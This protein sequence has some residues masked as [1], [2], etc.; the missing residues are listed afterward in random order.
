MKINCKTLCLGL[1][2]A[3]V[4]LTQSARAE[5]SKDMIDAAVIADIKAFALTEIVQ[6]SVSN[7]NQ[8]YSHLSQAEI[9]QL[10]QKWRAETKQE[11]QPLISATLSSPLSS[12]FT[13][14]QAASHGLY[15]EMFAMD[16]KGLNVGQS[17]ISSDYWQGDEA[18][19]Q[20]T[21][22][23]GAS[24]IFV[25]EAEYK[26]DIGIWASQVNFTLIDQNQKVIGAMTV[27]VNLTELARRQRLGL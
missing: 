9:E 17:S 7:Q 21:Y 12:Y 18:K 23:N 22:P 20:K 5:Y 25:D 4:L 16:N 6:Q 15:I 26:D 13:R 14:V 10:D 3:L 2:S 24:A 11:N 1:L 19:F 27:E 8:K